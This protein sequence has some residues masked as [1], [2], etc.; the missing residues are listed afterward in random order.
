[1][2]DPAIS[3]SPAEPNAPPPQPRGGP[4]MGVPPVIPPRSASKWYRLAWIILA[5][6]LIAALALLF[7]FNPAHHAF[8]PSCAFYRLTGLQCPGCGGLRAV[9]HLLHG[10]VLTALRFNPLFV[11]ALPVAAWFVWRRLWRG[12]SPKPIAQRTQARWAWTIF[13]ILVAFW[14]VRNLP[15]EIFKLPPE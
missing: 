7:G 9:H 15:L 13:A 8:Y 10:D 12:P 4:A 1:M 14:I 5:V 3:A 6:A 11:L 2:S